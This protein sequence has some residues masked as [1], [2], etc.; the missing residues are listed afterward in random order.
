VADSGSG[1]CSLHQ[2]GV[3][4]GDVEEAEGR[5]ETV[6]QGRSKDTPDFAVGQDITFNQLAVRSTVPGTGP[7]RRRPRPRRRVEIGEY[8]RLPKPLP[9]HRNRSN[10]KEMPF[11]EN[12]V[13]RSISSVRGAGR[14][15]EGCL[16]EI[17]VPP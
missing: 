9:L 13:F 17:V 5:F 14:R 8:E 12:P 7:A 6:V 15:E 10:R 2:T 3:A 16:R 1:Q 4:A 11:R